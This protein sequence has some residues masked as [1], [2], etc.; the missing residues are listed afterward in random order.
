MTNKK[1]SII[2][3]FPFRIFKIEKHIHNTKT[4]CYIPH[5]VLK[6]KYDY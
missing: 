2:K 1:I 4:Y 5:L 6:Y 3:H